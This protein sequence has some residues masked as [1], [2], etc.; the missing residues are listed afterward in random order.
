M[1][2]V[3][4]QKLVEGLPS[5]LR[6]RLD[7]TGDKL[8]A[9]NMRVEAGV[10]KVD[11]GRSD[12]DGHPEMEDMSGIKIVFAGDLKPSECEDASFA[13]EQFMREF[14]EQNGIPSIDFEPIN[15]RRG[16]GSWYQAGFIVQAVEPTRGDRVMILDYSSE[17]GMLTRSPGTIIGVFEDENGLYGFV[18]DESEQNIK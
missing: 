18:T 6:A 16:D 14:L 4:S 7:K 5:K 10:F 12:S 11:S 13:A 9:R 15:G 1:L 8:A 17:L 3:Q 2:P